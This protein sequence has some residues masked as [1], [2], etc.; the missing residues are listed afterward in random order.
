MLWLGNWQ[1]DKWQFQ[2]AKLDDFERADASAANGRFAPFSAS[3]R[4]INER[5][6]LI[7][8]IVRNSRNGFFVITPLE[9]TDGD[10]M[11]V[12]R[13]WIPQS[14]LREPLESTEV[15][16]AP[17]TISGRRGA[18][19]V[20]GLKLGE[21]PEAVQTW[22]VILQY[23]TLSDAARLLQHPLADDVMLLDP[24][25]ADG[26]ERQWT[27][28]GLPPERHLGYAV[29]WFA[30]AT[31]LTLIMLIMVFKKKRETLDE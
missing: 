29:Q 28:G 24:V 17:R 20:G 31:A 18:L 10:W 16:N 15:D 25:A 11:L 4:F 23:P 27:A 3:G 30:M 1:L 22:P 21:Q 5:Q 2:L 26:F 9:T 7:D 13:G 19:P 8:N 6:I 14:P 12:N